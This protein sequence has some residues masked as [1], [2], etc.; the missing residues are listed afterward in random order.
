MNVWGRRTSGDTPRRRRRALLV[1]GIAGLAGCAIGAWFDRAAFFEAWLVTW[2][3]LLG[4]AL[5]SMAQVMIHELTG[6]D[7]GRVLRPALEAATLTLPLLALLA[8]PLALGLPDLFA[9]ARPETVA[10]SPSLQAR[11]W[12]LSTVPFLARNA[13]MLIAWSALGIAVVRSTGAGRAAGSARARR[14]CVAGLIVYLLTVTVAAFDWIASLVPD[15][16][17]TAIGVRLGTAQFMASLAFA[18][19]FTVV[20]SHRRGAGLPPARDFQDFG[21]LLLTYAMMWAYIAV[22]QYLI[23][24][25]EDLPRETLWY[26]PRATTSWRWLVVAVVALEFVLPVAAMLFRSVKRDPWRL[27]TVCAL[28]LLGQWLDVLWLVAP[29]LRPAGFALHVLDVLALAGMGCLW[30][31]AVLH[32]CERLPAAPAGQLRGVPAH[33]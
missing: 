27:A 32:L 8:L 24:W 30:L 28:A 15:W 26:W 11:A 19:T 12:Y 5:A 22:T 29:S 6:G 25:A 1:V 33:G 16:S 9:W 7:W 3:F 21:N 13:L 23:N 31:Y 2:L 17:S 4:I 14:I 20:R 10:H 18:V